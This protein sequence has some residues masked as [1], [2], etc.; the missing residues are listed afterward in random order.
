MTWTSYEEMT[1]N[2]LKLYIMESRTSC[3]LDLPTGSLSTEMHRKTQWWQDI[4]KSQSCVH[5]APC[6]LS[7]KAQLGIWFTPFIFSTWQFFP[8]YTALSVK[9]LEVKILKHLLFINTNT[10]LLLYLNN[11]SCLK[12]GTLK[13]MLAFVKIPLSHLTQ[14]Q[15]YHLFM[16][17]SL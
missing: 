10:I 8:H 17:K 14:Y 11:S 12:T 5:S 9:F 6:L 2:I 15:K 4:V 1:G 3:M 13:G 7:D 16:L